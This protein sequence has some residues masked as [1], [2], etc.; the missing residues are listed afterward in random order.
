MEENKFGKN[1][2]RLRAKAGMSQKSLANL[3]QV[4][5]MLVSSY[6]RG[7]RV[8][9]FEMLF[10]LADLFDVTLDELVG[11]QSSKK[12]ENLELIN[13]LIQRRRDAWI[14]WE[15][16]GYMVFTSEENGY[17]Y[18]SCPLTGGSRMVS[19]MNQ[20]EFINFTEEVNRDIFYRS[21][22][23]MSSVCLDSLREKTTETI[24]PKDVQRQWAD[25]IPKMF[26]GSGTK[27]LLDGIEDKISQQKNIQAT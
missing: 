4:S 6:E 9:R 8:P 2:A 24:I 17:V 27:G 11:Y 16:V 7:V 12:K 18:L 14:F 21:Y 19:F 20:D 3:L 23:V 5:T 15:S 10:R 25:R 1:L 22:D 13:R 26:N